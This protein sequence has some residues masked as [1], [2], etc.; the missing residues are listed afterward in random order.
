MWARLLLS[1]SPDQAKIGSSVCRTS[2]TRRCRPTKVPTVRHS[3]CG[4][5]SANAV[6]ATTPRNLGPHVVRP[7]PTSAHMGEHRLPIVLPHPSSTPVNI[8]Y[9]GR[10]G[11]SN[12]RAAPVFGIGW[13]CSPATN[14]W[15][16][17][18][19]R[20]SSTRVAATC[21]HGYRRAGLGRSI[22]WPAPRRYAS[23]A[24]Q[25]QHHVVQVGGS[26]SA[27]VKRPHASRGT[28]SAHRRRRASVDASSST[29]APAA[30]TAPA[31]GYTWPAP[32][33]SQSIDP[34]DVDGL[35]T[36]VRDDLAASV[37]PT[38][39]FS[40]R[41]ASLWSVCWSLCIDR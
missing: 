10:H 9:R 26:L 23:R 37:A 5:S 39:G 29:I 1:D 13:R 20:R 12:V 27:T 36:L 25:Q 40:R 22:P 19:S 33:P 14:T 34:R 6:P 30:A 7:Q 38:T 3:V 11:R 17:A 16:L 31:T 24:Q 35:V 21:A 8:Y 18:A 4:L 32:V 28:P 41:L 15:P 2:I